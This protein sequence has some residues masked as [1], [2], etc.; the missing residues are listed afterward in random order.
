[1]KARGAP[2]WAQ[3]GSRNYLARFTRCAAA[4]FG[5]ILGPSWAILGPPWPFSGGPGG[6]LEANVGLGR[7]D[8]GVQGGQKLRCQKPL[9][10]YGISLKTPFKHITYLS[11]QTT[12][13]RHKV[14][15]TH[16]Q[17][18]KA[19]SLIVLSTPEPYIL[20]RKTNTQNRT[21]VGGFFPPPRF[22]SGYLFFCSEYKALVWIG[23]SGKAPCR[24]VGGFRGLCGGFLWSDLKGMLCV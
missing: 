1:L 17:I 6:F 14:H 21:L 8:R 10:T 13:S 4:R 22:C 3:E 9:K 19:P 2:R 5:P 15:E 18:D 11:N 24:F 7:L 16:P 12:G 23:R 20:N